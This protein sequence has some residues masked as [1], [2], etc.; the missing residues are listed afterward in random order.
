MADESLKEFTKSILLKDAIAAIFMTYLKSFQLE[1]IFSDDVFEKLTE[2]FDGM[3]HD[4]VAATFVDLDI[5]TFEKD[6]INY[7]GV[8]ELMLKIAGLISSKL[9]AEILLL[10]VVG[11]LKD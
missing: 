3:Y 6:G 8:D 10:E 4:Y 5:Q 1:G 7:I 2:K 11:N 9:A